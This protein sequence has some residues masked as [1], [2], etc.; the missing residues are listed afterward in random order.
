MNKKITLKKLLALGLVGVASLGVV[1]C[2][3]STTTTPAF[4]T[5]PT[6][7][8]IPRLT[9]L[10]STSITLRTTALKDSLLTE[11]F[12]AMNSGRTMLGSS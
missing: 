5:L 11:R 8:P 7:T 1:S 3:K 10:I 12:P 9:L 4:F 2:G 6:T